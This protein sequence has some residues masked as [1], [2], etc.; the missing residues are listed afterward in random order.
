MRSIEV[1]C[2]NERLSL[3]EMKDP[4]HGVDGYVFSHETRYGGHIVS[5]LP[6]RLEGGRREVLLR[7]EITPCWSVDKKML[8]SIIGGVDPGDGPIET[9][10]RELAEEVGYEITAQEL[11][12]LGTTFGAKSSDTVYHLFAV[13]LT[14]KK[15]VMAKGDGSVLEAKA[16]CVWTRNISDAVDPLVA[17]S[18]IRLALRYGYLGLSLGEFS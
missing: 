17:V 13:D 3:C 5:I 16:S 2:D 14:W 9:A 6:F 8:S 12:S 15:K 7:Q 10:M 18:F 4:E 11:R 1:L